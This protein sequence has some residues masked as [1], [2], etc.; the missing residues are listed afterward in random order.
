MD[1]NVILVIIGGS[2]LLLAL[3][4]A[5]LRRIFLSSVML[6]LLLG[7]VVGPYGL[8]LIDP[9][10]LEDSRRVLEE[11]A[12]VT[13]AMSLMATGLQVTKTDL[14]ENLGR[15]TAL[16]TVGMLGMWVV[17]GMGAWLLL[18]LPLWGALLLGAIMTPTDPVVA[19]ALV[20]GRLAERNLPRRLRRT[21]LI[22]SGANDGL[23]L[24]LVLLAVFMEAHPPEEA[25]SM[26]LLEA[27]KSVAV[28]VVVGAIVGVLSAR[29]VERVAHEYGADETN[30][31][32]YGLALALLT[33]G[34]VHLL[35]GSGVLAA[36]VAAL[37][38]S[39]LLESKLR[40][41]LDAVQDV[42]SKFFV[43]PA[44]TFFGTLLPWS[45][46]GELGAAGL[47]FGV[48]VLVV[49]RPPVV[50]VALMP[51]DTERREVVFLSWFGPVGV[52]AIFYAS[53][54]HRFVVPQGEKIFAAAALA[55]C[56]SIVAHSIT[57]TPG[58]LIFARRRALTTLKHPL[59]KGI[60]GDPTL[61]S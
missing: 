32:G 40:R 46:W 29:L 2:L 52:A 38:F 19:S 4:A 10:N 55:V 16:L 28:A 5:I 30:L 31:L 34:A 54:V 42:V 13:L 51:T 12:R 15:S 18:D 17:T 11:L 41:E 56:V 49:R 45:Q 36:F 58:V 48:W 60:D 33:L 53:Y 24:P 6:A 57:A 20:T 35:G 25:F 3:T 39:V 44:F 22:E 14:R 23:A 37:A 61:D 50:P 21:L 43:L 1:L 7:V 9:A 59:D 47:L 26:W 8:G 27:L